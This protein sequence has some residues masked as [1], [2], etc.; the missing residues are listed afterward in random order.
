MTSSSKL[1]VWVRKSEKSAIYETIFG[2]GVLGLFSFLMFQKSSGNL[3]WFLLGI[4]GLLFFVA[5]YTYGGTIRR[6]R[7]INS[8]IE[9][10]K[11]SENILVLRTFSY[12]VLGLKKLSE[13][14]VD[15]E[16]NLLVVKE[17]DYPIIDKK[18]IQGKVLCISKKNQNS[19]YILPQFFPEEIKDYLTQ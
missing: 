14:E 8:T 9:S 12:N 19:Y 7:I 18:T 16:L 3:L 15:I 5:I 6:G 10:L 13:K 2:F 1:S 17:C 11:F 4:S